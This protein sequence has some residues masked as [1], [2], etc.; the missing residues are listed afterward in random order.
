MLA[1]RPAT[2]CLKPIELLAAEHAESARFEVHHVHQADEMDAAVIEAVPA[3]A[4]GAL[5]IA[6]EIE[7]GIVGE[8]IVLAGHVERAADLGPADDLIAGVELLGFGEMRDVA[9][10]QEQGGALGQGVYFSDGSFE[11]GGDVLIRRLV[12]ADVAVA[13]LDE[14]EVGRCGPAGCCPNAR[15]ESTPPLTAQTRPVPAQAMQLRKPRRSTPSA[16]ISMSFAEERS[17]SELVSRLLFMEM[18]F[19]EMGGDSC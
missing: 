11:R 4:A 18:S 12:E 7:L 10:V 15:E 14:S 16:S 17:S 19:R 3:V 9:G 6:F 5:A 8:D 2:S 13:E 1:A